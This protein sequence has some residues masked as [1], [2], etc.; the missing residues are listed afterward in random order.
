MF[1]LCKE[2]LQSKSFSTFAAMRHREE[3][4]DVTIMAGGKNLK[5]H[6]IVLVATIPYF[7]TVFRYNMEELKDEIAIEGIDPV[8]LEALINF[9]YTSKLKIKSSCLR[10]V[11]EAS[12]YLQMDYVTNCAVQFLTRQMNPENVFA[13]RSCAEDIYNDNLLENADCYIREHFDEVSAT[14]MFLKLPFR[15]VKD[16]VCKGNLN[17]LR[18]AN[19]FKSVVKWVK[20]CEFG[21]SFHLPELLHNIRM[22]LMSPED[23]VNCI[24]EETLVRK[25]SSCMYIIDQAKSYHLLSRRDGGRSCEE[26]GKGCFTPNGF[27]VLGRYSRERHTNFIDSLGYGL[28][29]VCLSDTFMLRINYFDQNDDK[30]IPLCDLINMYPCYI[31]SNEQRVYIIHYAFVTILNLEK[32][33]D[34][35]TTFAKTPAFAGITVHNQKIYFFGGGYVNIGNEVLYLDAQSL[36]C[37]HEGYMCRQRKCPGIASLE[38]TIYITGGLSKGRET[39]LRAA[40]KYDTTT[41]L[42]TEISP[43][44]KGRWKHSCCTLQG[45]I[46][47]CGGLRRRDCFETSFTTTCQVYDSW[48]DKWSFIR[49]MNTVK[50]ALSLF[51]HGSKIYACGAKLQNVAHHETETYDPREE[52]WTPVNTGVLASEQPKTTIWLEN[53]AVSIM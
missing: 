28:Y 26:L 35:Y 50:K 52:E 23:I 5:G 43:M 30:W 19:I 42:S 13:I 40:E 53:S 12:M 9:A 6:R 22:H 17:I 10:S 32:M 3:F 8:A 41:G 47:A 20:F 51:P 2:D 34:S 16:L 45:K 29:S 24:S 18:E 7:K 38:N 21:R 14:S 25:R 31:A 33:E 4:C 15:V 11:L 39:V 27:T 48:V 49:C 1:E 46:Y 44:L 36:K 37:V